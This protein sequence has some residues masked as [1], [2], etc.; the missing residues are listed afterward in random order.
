MKAN[1]SKKNNNTKTLFMGTIIRTR[2]NQQHLMFTRHVKLKVC[3]MVLC[4]SSQL[5]RRPLF[6]QI[7]CA[8]QATVKAKQGRCRKRNKESNGG[9]REK[10]QRE[11][12]E[13]SIR[14]HIPEA[15]LKGARPCLLQG[16]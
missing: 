12:L 6:G 7:A 15:L 11:E 16:P 2:G 13:K 10:R 3:F 8:F 9:K 5:Y 14:E 4:I 1:F